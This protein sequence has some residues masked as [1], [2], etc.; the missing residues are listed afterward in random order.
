MT[1]ICVWLCGGQE[2]LPA[3]PVRIL[4]IE[5]LIFIYFYFQILKRHFQLYLNIKYW[6]IFPIVFIGAE[7][8][9]KCSFGNPINPGDVHFTLIDADNNR[10]DLHHELRM[11]EYKISYTLPNAGCYI[12]M[13]TVNNVAT[14]LIIVIG[15]DQ[16]RSVSMKT[17]VIN[18]FIEL[19]YFLWLSF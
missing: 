4:M 19:L 17:F 2:C 14:M 5:I 7:A 10:Q 12:I 18:I 16:P 13:V 6:F 11:G 3:S 1:L 8:E 15:F 9:F